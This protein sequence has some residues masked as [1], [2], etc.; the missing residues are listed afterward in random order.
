MSKPKPKQYEN[1]QGHFFDTATGKRAPQGSYILSAYYDILSAENE[2]LREALKDSEAVAG[3]RA[4][5][6]ADSKT[7]QLHDLL[8]EVELAYLSWAAGADPTR[9]THF[10]YEI[11]CIVRRYGNLFPL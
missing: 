4:D 3:H 11:R 5:K 1:Q 8:K 10:H 2:K 7:E 6:L 9:I